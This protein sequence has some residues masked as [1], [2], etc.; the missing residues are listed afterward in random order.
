MLLTNKLSKKGVSEIQKSADF[1]LFRDARGVS[2]MVAYV[3]LIVI[4]LAVGAM[5]YSWIIFNL[6]KDTKSCPDD[7]SLII[8]DYTCNNS[9]L[10]LV[11]QNKGLFDISGFYIRANNESARL[12]TIMLKEVGS[13]DEDGRVKFLSKL[14]SGKEYKSLFEYSGN[15]TSLEVEPFIIS[16]KKIVLCDKSIATQDLSCS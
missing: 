11:V 13:R 6:P 12:R 8:K 1:W 2:E 3:L 5:V 4:V 7:L 15:I 14:E 9:V 10:N 16:D